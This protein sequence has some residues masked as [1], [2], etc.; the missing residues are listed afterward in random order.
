LQPQFLLMALALALG[1]CAGNP[2][3]ALEPIA[4][5]APG[6][7]RVDML[8]VTTRSDVG[9]SRGEMFGGERSMRPS[10][11][12]ISILIPPESA[13]TVGEVQWPTSLPPDP[14]R[15]FATLSAEKVP[16]EVG[17]KRFRERLAK[18]P[19][20]RVLLFVHGYNTRFEESVFRLAQIVHDSKA[21]VLP[22]L[23]TWPS[24]GKLLGYAYDRESA[25]Y[26]RDAL[27]LTLQK[28]IQAHDVGEVTL[29]AH[30]MGNWVALEALRQLAIRNGGIH[31]K[32]KTVMLAAPDVDVDVFRRQ[33][34][35]I[36]PKRPPFIVILSRDDKALAMSQRVWGDTP[37][38][39][40]M[41]PNDAGIHQ[42]I[43]TAGLQVVDL[44]DMKST[45]RLNHG[46]FAENPEVVR[47]IGGRLADGQTLSDSKAGLGDRIGMIT[48]DAVRTVG[49]AATVT[50]SAPIAIIDPET[51]KNL[52]DQIEDLGDN[53]RGAVRN[54]KDIVQ[55][56]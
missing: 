26:S 16:P 3:G 56:Q 39:G 14:A 22:V 24:R 23:F 34:E 29:L 1:G 48:T 46:K 30:S 45:D 6:S 27:E 52:G 13:R 43:K 49:R 4:A 36:G 17:L 31:P 51:R 2:V 9:V 41:D 15:E 55:S 50:V 53:A 33:V 42:M 44:T 37:R 11:A 20:R 47:M 25:N 12:D 19:G 32:I 38:L 28:L 40:A 54:T 10:F 7:S 35:M 18:V 21:P 5:A 8:V